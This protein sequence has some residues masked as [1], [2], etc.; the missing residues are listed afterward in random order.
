ME[1]F[2]KRLFPAVLAEVFQPFYNTG[3][4]TTCKQGTN[5]IADCYQLGHKGT[6]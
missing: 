2:K 3:G 4:I 5:P 1:D 6:A